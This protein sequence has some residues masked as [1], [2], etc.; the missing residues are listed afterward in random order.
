MTYFETWNKRIEEPIDQTQ[1]TA[2][3]QHYY[4]LEKEAYNR[5]LTN[6]PDN[7]A[8]VSGAAGSLAKTLGF[9][10]SEMEIFVGFVDG[11]NPSLLEEIKAE[12]ITDETEILLKIDYEKLYWN[13]HDA[14]ADW[15]YSLPSWE[16]VISKEKRAEISKQYR[17]SKTVHVD[18]IGRNDPCPCG[19][20]KK[21]KKCCMGETKATEE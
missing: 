19:S 21:Y 6:Y 14:K 13:M 11:I 17:E 18:K 2:Y 5:I 16:H 9:K 8:Y 7:E 1:Y 3:V 4:E 15:L 20:G 10:E 12:E